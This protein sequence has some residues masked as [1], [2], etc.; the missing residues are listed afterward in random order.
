AAA[1]IAAAFPGGAVDPSAWSRVERA[2]L[3]ALIGYISESQKGVAVALRPPSS[4]RLQSHMAI[5]A[6]TRASLE[7]LETPRG[8]REGSL[9]GEIDQ[10]V[11]PAGSRLLARRLAAPLCEPGPIN[12]RLDA[13]AC[14]V[15]EAIVATQVRG[16]L[17]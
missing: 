6:A 4:E 2:A 10:C 15:G 13:V 3:G 5:D 12:A 9:L 14:L 7:L 16:A 8:T 1:T 11:T 17:K